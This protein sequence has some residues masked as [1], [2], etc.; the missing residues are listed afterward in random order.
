[1]AS[2]AATGSGV[3]GGVAILSA[4][5]SPVPRSGTATPVVSVMGIEASGLA[6]AARRY[7]GA[8]GRAGHA[9]STIV[10]STGTFPENRCDLLVPDFDALYDVLTTRTSAG[11]IFWVGLHTNDRGLEAQ[12]ELMKGARDAGFNSIVVP[13]RTEHEEDSDC[14]G[15]VDR[16][17][18]L[19]HGMVSF[20]EVQRSRWVRRVPHVD[21]VVAP[22][23]IP[24]AFFQ[25]GRSRLASAPA[26]L[27][28]PVHVV[29]VGR[30]ARRKGIDRLL[31]LWPEIDA[32]CRLSGVET[33]LTL[34]GKDFGADPSLSHLVDGAVGDPTTCVNWISD[35]SDDP[36][37]SATISA[38]VGVSLSTQEFDAI[39]VTEMMAAGLPVVLS[40]TSGHVAVQQE[41]GFIRLVSSDADV[42]NA[43]V[44]LCTNA[45]LR[46]REGHAGMTAIA[47]ARSEEVVVSRLL[48]LL[49]G[50]NFQSVP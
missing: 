40:P 45:R 21:H 13:E 33:R 38:D 24:E 25:A 11:P 36:R 35:F 23:P 28:G 48:R 34:L 15:F 42:V 49:R 16:A 5:G 3:L 12:L 47:A 26:R 4:L 6:I 27:R 46:S 1:M 30:I 44:N 31:R 50:P 18:D 19:V 41:C 43:L 9:C 32:R 10:L 7:A 2:F 20:N 17:S 22:P 39:A 8:L 29:A 14:M 37:L